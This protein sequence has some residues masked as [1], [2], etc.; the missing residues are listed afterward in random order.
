MTLKQGTV[1]QQMQQSKGHCQATAVTAPACPRRNGA[2]RTAG[3]VQSRAFVHLRS[4]SGGCT[5]CRNSGQGVHESVLFIRCA[6]AFAP[7]PTLWASDSFVARH[8]LLTWLRIA[9][10]QNPHPSPRRRQRRRSQLLVTSA[11]RRTPR[12]GS[13]RYVEQAVQRC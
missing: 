6:F 5:S 2:P 12:G 13:R 11:R 10:Q 4:C 3:R 7:P 1:V 8:C 9:P